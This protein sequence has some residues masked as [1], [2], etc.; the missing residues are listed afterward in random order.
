MTLANDAGIVLRQF[1]AAEQW[2]GPGHAQNI[3]PEP[4]IKRQQNGDSDQ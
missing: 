2:R 3:Y 1:I 4:L